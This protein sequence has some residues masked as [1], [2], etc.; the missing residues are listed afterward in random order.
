MTWE[1]MLRKSPFDA[2][3]MRRDSLKNMK[4]NKERRL[5]KF[6]NILEKY[7]DKKLE[8]AIR[9]NPNSDMVEIKMSVGLRSAIKDLF[10]NNI[11]LSKL[12][13]IMEK[14][15]NVDEV[16]ITLTD[17]KARITFRGIGM[18]D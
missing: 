2:G 16:E 11:P 4:E 10:G 17:S 12:E 14:E 18:R 8:D 6:L 3:Q 5:K 7:V 15:Y 1:D 9:S 13:Q